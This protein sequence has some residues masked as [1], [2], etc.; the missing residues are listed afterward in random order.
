MVGQDVVRVVAAGFG[1]GVDERG[2]QPGD[3]VQQG[4]LGADGDLMG[5]ARR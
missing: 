4:M 3:R 2:G 5:L 1:V